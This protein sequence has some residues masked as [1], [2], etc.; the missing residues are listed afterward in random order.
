MDQFN[1]TT[2]QP[3][4]TFAIRIEAQLQHDWSGGILEWQVE[5][6]PRD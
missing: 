3:L 6:A 4:E 1:R 5:E 2:F